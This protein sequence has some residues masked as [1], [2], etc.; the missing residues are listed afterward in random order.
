M[1][2]R[3]LLALGAVGC[4]LVLP[5]LS[6]AEAASLRDVAYR[7]SMPEPKLDFFFPSEKGFPRVVHVY[8]SGWRS[9]SGK[10]SI[11]VAEALQRHGVGCVL[12]SHRLAPSH[13]IAAQAEDVAAAFAWAKA[14]VTESGGDPKRLF[15]C[16]HSTGGH[17][18]ALVAVDPNAVKH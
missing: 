2:C 3:L 15:L 8:G 13:P 9:G 17:L 16:G 14:H 6:D 1:K 10:S 12:V 7:D 11:P 4:A 18:A 5:F